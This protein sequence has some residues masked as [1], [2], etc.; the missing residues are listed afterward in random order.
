LILSFIFLFYLLISSLIRNSSSQQPQTPLDQ[1]SEIG[2]Q[3]PNNT[4]ST[5]VSGDTSSTE[6]PTHLPPKLAA[7]RSDVFFYLNFYPQADFIY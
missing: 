7:G 2:S 3:I 6:T 4:R 5:S 1:S